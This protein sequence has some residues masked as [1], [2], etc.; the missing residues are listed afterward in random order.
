M[1]ICLFF[2]RLPP[3]HMDV[4]KLGDESKLQ[5]PACTTAT[6]TWLRIRCCHELWCRSPNRVCDLH[7]SSW[8]HLILNPMSKARDRTCILMDPSQVHFCSTTMETPQQ[9]SFEGLLVPYTAKHFR[10]LT[11][12]SHHSHSKNS[13]QSVQPLTGKMH[14][15]PGPPC[16]HSI[17]TLARKI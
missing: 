7:H 2:L 6:A 3:R 1:F 15:Y 5:L 14:P 8:Q 16:H 9:R 17:G 10:S 11:L 4:P 13:S 12:L